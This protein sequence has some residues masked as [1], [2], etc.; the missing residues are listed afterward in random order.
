MATETAFR[1][2]TDE[3]TSEVFVTL[4]TFSSSDLPSP[5]RFALN[6][7]NIISNGDTY[8]ASGFQYKPP[9]QGDEAA[10]TGTLRLDNL[11]K[12]ITDAIHQMSSSPD[13]TIVEVLVSDPDTPQYTLPPFKFFNINWNR[14]TVEGT[15]GVLD[16]Q[17]EPSVSLAY[18]PKHAPGLFG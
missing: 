2:A 4:I 16:D 17:D 9:T 10:S 11:D 6:D 5:L 8:L 13:I 18:T 14:D 3:A 7:E 12:S 15:I 1:A